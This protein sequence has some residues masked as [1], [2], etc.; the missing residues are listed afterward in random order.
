MTDPQ[1]DWLTLHLVP[2]LGSVGFRALLTAFG[3]AAAVLRASQK[4]LQGVPG[5]RSQVISAITTPSPYRQAAEHELQRMA[6]LGM[7]MLCFG[8]EGYPGLLANIFNPPMTLFVKGNP[9]ALRKEGLAVVGSRAATSYGLKVA[10]DFSAQ[11]ASMGVVIVS[12]LALGIDTAAHTGALTAGGETVA[13]LGCGLDVPYPRAN[14]RLA[15]QIAEAGAVIS[16]YPLATPPDAFR[17]PARNRIIS[18]LTRGVLVV[19]AAQRSGSLITARLALEEG[20]EVFAIPGRVDSLKSSGTH[21]LLQEGAKL[22]GT[23]DDILEELH[24][25]LSAPTEGS[26]AGPPSAAPS[27]PLSANEARVIGLLDVYPKP[28]DTII[29]QSR[30]PAA[31]VSEVLLL[32][33]LQGL[34]ESLP[35]QQYRAVSSASTE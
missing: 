3:S 27:P 22:V 21:R 5:I 24:W 17:F 29:T 28:I 18:G 20:R 14:T 25:R 13:V 7:V 19:E 9:G 2:G 16:E 30:L 31:T 4:D 33:E 11:L 6:S 1:Q 26:T 12:G 8:D 35:G 34:I 23:I 32:L 10:R 15:C